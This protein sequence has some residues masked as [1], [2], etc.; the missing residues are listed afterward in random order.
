MEKRMNMSVGHF[1][2]LFRKISQVTPIEYL[3]NIRIEKAKRMLKAD[4]KSNISE[5]AFQC[6][7]SDLTYFSASFKKKIGESPSQFRNS[8]NTA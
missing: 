7:Y 1:T 3:T 4:Y 5:I 8:S 2:R 6:G